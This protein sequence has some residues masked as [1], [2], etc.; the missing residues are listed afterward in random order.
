VDSI[1]SFDTWLFQQING[2]VGTI[3]LFDRFMSVVVNEYFITVT[4]SLVLVALWFLGGSERGRFFNQKAV[5][6][7]VLAQAIANGIVKLNNLLYYRPRPFAAMQVHLLFY[8]PT[9][10][11]FPSNPATV[12]FAFA[13]AVWMVNRRVGAVF[14]ALATLFSFSRVYCGVHYPLDVVGGAVVGTVGGVL[15]VML[16]RGPLNSL[17]EWFVGLGRRLYIA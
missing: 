10:S 5:A 3:P 4:L 16:G 9:D 8:E 17:V 12:G 15:A 14:F 7:A 6:Y 13:A 11:S 1:A 2:F